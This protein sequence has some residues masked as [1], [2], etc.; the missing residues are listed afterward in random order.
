MPR[1]SPC[2]SDPHTGHVPIRF[3]GSPI[4]SPSSKNP[5]IGFDKTSVPAQQIPNQLAQQIPR[6][7][8]SSLHRSPTNQP[9][10]SPTLGYTC[11]AMA[12]S[13]ASQLD[14]TSGRSTQTYAP[15]R[16][17]QIPCADEGGMGVSVRHRFA[18]RRRRRCDVDDSGASTCMCDR[19]IGPKG[20]IMVRPEGRTD[21]TPEGQPASSGLIIEL[22]GLKARLQ[23]SLKASPLQ[24][25]L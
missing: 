25:G 6:T 2:T 12:A 18:M 23:S 1:R 13:Y 16:L 7:C 24:A 20:P 8:V 19:A 22:S 11:T 21:G 9:A 15:D 10:N 4:Q 5:D 17:T 14:E 3:H